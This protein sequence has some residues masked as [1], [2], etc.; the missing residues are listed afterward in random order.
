MGPSHIA[1]AGWKR[2]VLPL[3]P[4]QQVQPT[5]INNQRG[6]DTSTLACFP[7]SR[8]GQAEQ[9]QDRG[10]WPVPLCQGLRK[11]GICLGH[12]ELE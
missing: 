7:V 9:G 8:R 12:A 11:R 5:D 2:L 6:A 1:R 3:P 4:T 10:G